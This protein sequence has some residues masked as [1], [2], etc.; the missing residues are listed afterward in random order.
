MS[1]V[2]AHFISGVWRKKIGTTFTMWLLFALGSAMTLATSLRYGGTLGGNVP[3]AFDIPYTWGGALAVY[4]RQRRDGRL[5]I[6]TFDLWCIGA[7][8]II[9]VW[10][11]Y[12]QEH[13]TANYLLQGV[14][15]IAYLPA[16]LSLWRAWCNK[17]SYVQW[18]TV[19]LLC[20]AATSIAY[21]SSAAGDGFALLYISRA[22]LMVGIMLTLM[23]RIDAWK[24]PRTHD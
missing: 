7:T 10:W 9:S 14:M 1:A 5:K 4:L 2:M 18:G 20:M 8:L 6:K 13:R 24:R 11:L 16:F 17:E 22:T 15:T 3:N 23:V 19:F 21:Q 12:A